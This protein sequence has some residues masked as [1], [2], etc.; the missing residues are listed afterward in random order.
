MKTVN[1]TEFRKNSSEILDLV[2]K[3]ESIVSF[4]QAYMKNRYLVP[5]WD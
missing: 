1:F 5:T 2:E 3:G 4:R